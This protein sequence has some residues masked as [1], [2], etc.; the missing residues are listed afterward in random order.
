MELVGNIEGP[1][2]LIINCAL[3]PNFSIYYSKIMYFTEINDV[4]IYRF[5]FQPLKNKYSVEEL[6]NSHFI[7]II[8]PL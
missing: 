6:F 1:I 2:N 8:S 3:A 5:T 7:I 4:H